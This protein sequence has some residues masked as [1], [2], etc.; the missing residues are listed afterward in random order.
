[1]TTLILIAALL[2]GPASVRSRPRADPAAPV[3]VQKLS[4]EELRAEV[5]SYLGSIDTPISDARWRSLG[6]GAAP[7]L[8]PVIDDPKALPTDRARALE[9]LVAVSPER[10]QALVVKLAQGEDE[11]VVVRVAALHGA[12]RLLGPRRLLAAVKP[13]LEGAKEPG[14]RAT[15][16]EVLAHHGK[17]A[18]CTAVR[19]QAAREADGSHFKRAL[20]RCE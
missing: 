9:G 10:A 18:G 14:M 17:S 8:E 4:P 13:V 1:M 2:A 3:A 19:A 16:A 11:P 15:A 6:P 7:L 20:E 12:A 5:K